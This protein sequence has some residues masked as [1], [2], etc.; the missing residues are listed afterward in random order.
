MK[1]Y[2]GYIRVSTI[3]QGEKGSSL[4]EQR[5]AILIYAAK[6]KLSVCEFFEE[7]QTAAK[8]GRATFRKMLNRLKRGGA[9][10]LIMHKVDRGARNLADWA[11]IAALKDIGIDVHFAHEAIDLN[12]RGGRLSADIQAV[13]ASDFIRN[14]RDEVKKGLYGRLKQGMYPFQ[15]PPG[16]QNTG[17]GQL[18]S[19]HDVQGPLMREAFEKYAGG[20]FGLHALTAYMNSRGLRNS[21]GNPFC[22]SGLAVTLANPFYYG[23]L[24]VKGQSFVG[25]HTP[26]ITKCLFDQCRARAEG[27]LVSKTR[28]WGKAEYRFRGLLTCITC[29]RHL[30]AETQKGHVYYR[31]AQAS[32]KG[33]CLRESDIA[34]EIVLPFSYIPCS[35][36]LTQSLTEM[37]EI[38]TA[39]QDERVQEQTRI[40]KLRRAQLA[41]RTERLTD[42]LIEGTLSQESYQ[43]RTQALQKEG[44]DLAEELADTQN[45]DLHSDRLHKYLELVKGLQNMAQTPKEHIFREYAKS[46]I[47]NLSVCQKTLEIS[48]SKAVLMLLDMGGFY[49]GAHARNESRT[50]MHSITQGD[51]P[52]NHDI[53]LHLREG[54]NTSQCAHERNES[55]T[56]MH[57][58]T[59]GDEPQNH[60]IRPHFQKG[61]NTSQCAHA[62]NESRTCMHSITQSD[63]PKN[64]DIPPHLREGSNT[65]QCAH[66]RNESRTC[67]H[68]ITQ[69]DEPQNHDIPP[70]LREGSNMSQCAHVRNESRTCI[71][72]ATHGNLFQSLCSICVTERDNRFKEKIIQR[73]GELFIAII[74]DKSLDQIP[75]EKSEVSGTAFATR[76]ASRKSQG[77]FSGEEPE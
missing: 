8:L 16:Y 74:Y 39:K 67:M 43:V 2:Y 52:Q 53:P 12:S 30:Y 51:E 28:V 64:H 11:E 38:H 65:S 9:D 56:C 54:N 73:G 49:G 57:S 5:D 4:T 37:F 44:F 61:G 17:K 40:V 71:Y 77:I 3:K 42:L 60:D 72:Y 18:K 1:K 34:A 68:S 21:A 45:G 22:M 6:N 29:K 15:A 47:S 32:C 62:R 70:H 10:G 27:R 7:Q 14:L 24:L 50:C 26:L 33:T 55:R 66:E 31:C 76:F 48:W 69:G 35:P 25:K 13:V 58:I 36:L 41:A 20:E 19:I 23:L 46:A 63:E 59:Q 75:I